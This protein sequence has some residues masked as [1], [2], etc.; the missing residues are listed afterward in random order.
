MPCRVRIIHCMST[1]SH[2]NVYW[3]L[4]NNWQLFQRFSSSRWKELILVIFLQVTA[5]FY[6][7]VNNSRNGSTP[8]CKTI[9][10]GKRLSTVFE[11]SWLLQNLGEQGNTDRQ[12][13]CKYTEHDSWMRRT[14]HSQTQLCNVYTVS[15]WYMDAEVKMY[16]NEYD[17]IEHVLVRCYN[18]KCYRKKD[19]VQALHVKTVCRR[20][21]SI[22]ILGP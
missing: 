13:F 15:T 11:T 9:K 20:I 10:A 3:S 22:L 21:V 5:Q 4:Q 6:R 19:I 2:F 17:I 12:L 7:A 18:L 8:C 16:W 14:T 1:L